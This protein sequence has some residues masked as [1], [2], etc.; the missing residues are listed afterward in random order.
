MKK[1]YSHTFWIVLSSITLICSGC[2][3]SRHSA[4]HSQNKIQQ[5][6]PVKN[7]DFASRQLHYAVDKYPDSTRFPRTTHRNGKIKEVPANDW[8]SGFFPGELWLMYK[9]TGKPFWKAKA[10]AWTRQLSSQQYNTHTHDVGFMINCSYGNGLKFTGNNK[11]KQVIINAAKSLVTRFNPKVGAIKS[12]DHTKWEYPVIID[13][14]MNLVLLFHATQVSGDSTFY[15]IAET[16]AMTTMK[17]LVRSNGSTW[18]VA[19][20]DTTTGKVIWRGTHQGYANNSTW[21]RGEAWALYGFTM[22]YRYTKD[23]KLLNTA[24]KI[25]HFILTNN[26]L[27][28]N[29]LPY[30]DYDDPSIPNA[31]KDASAAAIMSSGF[32]QLS[33]FVN[34]KLGSK[35]LKAARKMLSSLSSPG[36]RA[37]GVGSN[38]GFILKRSVG[39]KPAGSEISVPEVYADYYY[40]EANLRYLNLKER[41]KNNQSI[42]E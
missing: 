19:G 29:Y 34:N 30:W 36:F 2:K 14:M 4:S 27:P 35:Y 5:L 33:G 38:A 20:F 32:I 39:N 41:G 6:D 12:W 42:S 25:A 31:P 15:H 23:I 11:Y 40:I 7:L 9:Y 21:A 28:D 24:K 22:A 3:I 16:H 18:H 8:T 26:H 13:N 1:I 17:I 10:E 37:K